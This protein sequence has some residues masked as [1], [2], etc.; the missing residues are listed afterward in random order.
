[1]RRLRDVRG[2]DV[3]ERSFQAT[4]K[5]PRARV[6]RFAAQYLYNDGDLYYF[7]NT[8]TFDQIPVR[9][10]VLGDSMHYMKENETYELSLYQDQPIGVELPT[11]VDLRV[12]ETE[13]G[14]KGDTATGG[15]KPA[16]LDTGVTV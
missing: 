3:V 5:F 11:A 14:F 4:E 2:G 16:R 6:E 9:A 13:P 15:N 12:L 7:M 10:E 8:A 1:G